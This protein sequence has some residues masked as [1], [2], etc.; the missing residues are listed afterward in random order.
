MDLRNELKKLPPELDTEGLVEGAHR[1]R[2]RRQ[3]LLA[4]G[5]ALAVVAVATPL[6]VNVFSD[7]GEPAAIEDVGT[8]EMEGE[9]GP[10]SEDL[11]QEESGEVDE[12]TELPPMGDWLYY[13][14]LDEL[15]AASDLVVL[16][17]ATDDVR[18]EQ[19]EPLEP[20]D[21]TDPQQNPTL[22][23]PDAEPPPPYTVHIRDL[24]V[25]DTI[26]GD[27]SPGT[28]IG[29]VEEHGPW[30]T[31]MLEGYEYLLFLSRGQEGEFY[32]VTPGQGMYVVEDGLARDVAQD[33]YG[34][35]YGAIPLEEI[36]ELI[37]E[38]R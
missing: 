21:P 4:G 34:D 26:R 15:L 11:P 5:L 36:Q 29:L 9:V 8:P 35:P 25:N 16:A 6:A 7:K 28:T 14:T 10:M 12:E 13:S 33:P 19:H 23:V 3:Q 37:E 32:L 2:R 20:E 31:G 22:G 27:V 30:D 18:T 17:T 24:A 1:K 38:V